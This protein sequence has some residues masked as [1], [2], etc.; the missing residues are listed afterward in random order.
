MAAQTGTLDLNLLFVGG[1]PVAFN[2]AYHQSG[3]VF[4]LRTGFDRAAADDGAG[5]V[6]QARM[7][8]DC[9]ARGDHTYD[10]GPGYLACK[11][12]WQTHTKYSYRY[13]HFPRHVPLAQLVRAKRFVRHWLGGTKRPI[14][15]ENKA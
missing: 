7:I 1:R 13:T 10:L 15:S 3:Y 12:Y 8:E 6:L 2:Y 11:R 9:F 4:G 5:S 14:A